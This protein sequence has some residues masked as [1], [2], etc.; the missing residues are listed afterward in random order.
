MHTSCPLLFG[1]ENSFLEIK[2]QCGEAVFAL[3]GKAVG[4]RLQKFT[5]SVNFCKRKGCSKQASPEPRRDL[6]VGFE[7]RQEGALEAPF[8]MNQN[9]SVF[10]QG[11]KNM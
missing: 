3:G 8:A 7:G 10:W 5:E 4:T 11:T 6:A 1:I 9:G 2:L